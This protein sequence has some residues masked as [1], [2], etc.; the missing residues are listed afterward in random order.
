MQAVPA[1][2]MC[3]VRRAEQPHRCGAERKEASR[4]QDWREKCR[5]LQGDDPLLSRLHRQDDEAPGVV[6]A[7]H[8]DLAVISLL[9]CSTSPRGGEIDRD[10]FCRRR[11]KE[12]ALADHETAA[13]ILA[14]A[15]LSK[16]DRPGV[17]RAAQVHTECLQ[18]IRPEKSRRYASGTRIEDISVGFR[19]R[20]CP[21]N[22][23]VLN[24]GAVRA[25]VRRR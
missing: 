8:N 11:P 13:A 2:G 21:I 3:Q 6:D 25:G 14:A 16:E 5:G 23:D 9:S 4:V 12:V 17:Q 1:R 24:L 22:D 20:E 19:K 15:V 18:A 10:V 7:D